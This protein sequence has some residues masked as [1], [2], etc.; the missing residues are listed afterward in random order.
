LHVAFVTSRFTVLDDSMSVALDVS[1]VRPD[2][3]D[4]MRTDDWFRLNVPIETNETFVMVPQVLELKFDA[5]DPKGTYRII[6]TFRD[7][8]SGTRRVTDTLK[9]ALK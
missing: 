1:V 2:G 6:A 3:R 8:L 9:V 7:L 5:A 4:L